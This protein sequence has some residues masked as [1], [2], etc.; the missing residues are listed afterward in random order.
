MTTTSG[1]FGLR[2]VYHAQGGEIRTYGYVNGIASGYAANIYSGDRVIMQTSGYL[3]QATTTGPAIGVFVG[4]SYTDANGLPQFATQW[5]SGLSAS[6]ITV[7]V[8]RD[9]NVIYEV[10]ANG[11]LTQASIGDEY[12]MAN[13]GVGSLGYSTA[14]LSTTAAGAGSTKT[15]RV[16][17]LGLGPYPGQSNTWGDTYTVV[18]VMMSVQSGFGLG[19]AI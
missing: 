10:Q 12:D 9:P 13:V 19:A 11:S 3:E 8:I 1:G 2:P 14:Q 16:V 7:N 17:G 15:L 5:T 4:V 6:G 18:Q